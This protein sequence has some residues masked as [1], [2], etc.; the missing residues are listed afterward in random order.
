MRIG[1]SEEEL[2]MTRTHK[3]LA[4]VALTAFVAEAAL[5]FC[6]AINFK[7]N[8][9]NP[10][11]ATNSGNFSVSFNRTICGGSG[12]N[13][14][15]FTK[16]SKLEQ[17]GTAV[18]AHAVNSMV[19]SGTDF[20]RFKDDDSAYIE[21][22]I[23]SNG[24]FQEITG[25]SFVYN[26]TY[27]YGDFDIY[28]S[29]DGS[30]YPVSPN[31]QVRS[32]PASVSLVGNGI[33]KVK[34]AGVDGKYAYFNTIT[35]NYACGEAP[36]K[37]LSSISVEGQTDTFNVDDSFVFDGTVTAHYSDSS[38][39]DVTSSAVIDSSDVDMSTAGDYTVNVSYSDEYGSANTSYSITVNGG[40]E[41]TSVTY[42]NGSGTSVYHI[43]IS[44]DNTGYYDYIYTA[45]QSDPVYYTIHF[46]WS[47]SGSTYTYTK[48]S[49][50]GDSEYSGSTY[51][52]RSLFGG[53]NT[54][55]TGA[56]S[57]DN[58]VIQLRNRDGDSSG[59]NT[60]FSKIS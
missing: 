17:S 27:S 1:S 34:F 7:G 57:G 36:A 3:K 4:L 46:T 10:I 47:L 35:I 54:T 2:I 38:S 18:Y 56:L 39:A 33:K 60:T 31:A 49:Q 21:F 22:N 8:M 30:T 5:I 28:L 26:S 52:Y 6:V 55:N 45:W 43:T 53:S 11:K 24:S 25:F 48:N 20:A 23:D 14:D 32:A 12:Y 16:Q 44:S 58:I 41:V 50:A 9:L 29:T 59:S 40:G 51:Y 15:D 13:S 37:T 42:S 19:T